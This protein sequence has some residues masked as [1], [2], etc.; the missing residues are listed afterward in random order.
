[1]SEAGSYDPKWVEEYFDDFA[2]QEW[3]RLKKNP[4]REVQLSIHVQAIL[5]NLTSNMEILEIGAGPGRFTHAIVEVLESFAT[6]TDISEVQLDLNRAKAEEHGFARGVREWRKLDICD[7][8]CYKDAS[9]DAIVAYGGPLSYV[10]D[11]RNIAL[12]ECIRVVKPGGIILASVMSL[13]GTIHQYLE[14]VLGFSRTENHKIIETGDLTTQNA[15]FATHFCHMF[16]AVELRAFF[17]THGLEVVDMAASNVL[18]PAYGDKL[19]EIRQDKDKWMQVLEMEQKACRE[20]GCLDM[21]THLIISG[22]KP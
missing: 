11:R 4:A 16:R 15:Q 6:V 9:F 7:M 13:W 5:R 8:S 19:D 21:G 14:G 12:Q 2:D 10:L 3:D 22:R 17:E 1:M 18:T 20:P